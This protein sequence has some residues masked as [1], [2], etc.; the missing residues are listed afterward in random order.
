MLKE[1]IFKTATGEN[2]CY[3]PK[4]TIKKYLDINEKI[5]C[6]S[7]GKFVPI[8]NIEPQGLMRLQDGD[9]GLCIRK[10]PEINIVTVNQRTLSCKFLNGRN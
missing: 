5:E 8:K 1:K 7:C 3:D 4:T 6:N 9:C 2:W 10:D